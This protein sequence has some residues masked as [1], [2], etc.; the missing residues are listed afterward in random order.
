MSCVKGETMRSATRIYAALLGV[1]AELLLSAMAHAN[2]SAAAWR[3]ESSEQFRQGFVAGIASYL[4]ESGGGGANAGAERAAYAGCLA[5]E[6]DG[7]L[8]D[9][10]DIWL[11]GHAEAKTYAPAVAVTLALG[12][13]CNGFM[14]RKPV[15]P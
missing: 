8:L 9:V 13:Y 6:T 15:L 2:E 11:D 1:A 10:V 4:M 14:P 7:S 12:D 5:G 3:A